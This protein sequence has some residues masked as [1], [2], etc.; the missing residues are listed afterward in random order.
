M[1]FYTSMGS[2]GFQKYAIMSYLTD[3]IM[4]TV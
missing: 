4:D 2:W 1:D 3:L